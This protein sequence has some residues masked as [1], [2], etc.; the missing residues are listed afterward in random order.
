[1]PVGDLQK[2]VTNVVSTVLGETAETSKTF[3]WLINKHLPENFREHFPTIED[4]FNLLNGDI[5]ANQNKRIVRLPC[6]A[7][8]DKH[9]FI[10]EFDEYQHFTA[11]RLAT[12]ELYPKNLRTNYPVAKWQ[13]LCEVNHFRGDAYRQNK[14]TPDFNFEGGRT[15]QRAYF[16]CFRDLLPTQNGLNPTLRISSFDIE[17]VLIKGADICKEIEKILDTRLQ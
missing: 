4:I 14:V 5:N 3:D 17:K 10:F 15:A 9:K 2:I 16:D 6:D 12:F 11:A 1:M 8:F 7:Y 13:E